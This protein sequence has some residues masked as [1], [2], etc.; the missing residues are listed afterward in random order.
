MINPVL[1]WHGLSVSNEDNFTQKPMSHIG[2]L[3]LDFVTKNVII[4]I[5]TH[6]GD[7]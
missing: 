2:S 3:L 7:S 6:A 1:G 4:S 5:D